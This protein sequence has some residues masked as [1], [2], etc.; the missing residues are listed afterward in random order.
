MRDPIDLPI[1]KK[2][3]GVLYLKN[4][5]KTVPSSSEQNHISGPLAKQQPIREV[6]SIPRDLTPSL[7]IYSCK[8]EPS[9]P[10]SFG[11]I[12]TR[13]KRDTHRPPL[14]NKNTLVLRIPARFYNFQHW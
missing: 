12:R 3:H 4:I 1:A 14:A 10:Q 7:H 6:L 8:E 9:S 2:K 5:A 11:S 13:T